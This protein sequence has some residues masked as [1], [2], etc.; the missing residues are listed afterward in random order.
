MPFD[1]SD[2][3]VKKATEKLPDL[4]DEELDS[5]YDAELEGKGRKSMLDAITAARDD[6]R[7]ATPA[8]LIH[9]LAHVPAPAP[10]AAP[11]PA[12]AKAPAE[13]ISED[14]FMRLTW[15]QRQHWTCAGSQRYVKLG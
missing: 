15:H 10:S 13:G 2:L 12:P 8:E 5:L 14:A 9:E 6:I 4:S 11:K 7:E 3:T 1:P